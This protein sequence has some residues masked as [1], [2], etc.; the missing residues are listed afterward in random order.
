MQPGQSFSKTS[1]TPC[2]FTMQVGETQ[3][4]LQVCDGGMSV[5]L[6]VHLH[7]A[8]NGNSNMIYFYLLC[9]FCLSCLQATINC[10]MPTCRTAAPH[11]PHQEM[12][13]LASVSPPP[14][15]IFTRLWNWRQVESRPAAGV[16]WPKDKLGVSFTQSHLDV[17]AV[18]HVSVYSE[19]PGCFD[20]GLFFLS[21]TVSWKLGSTFC[22]H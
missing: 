3:H 13:Q 22:S 5:P 12:G 20:W 6:H 7:Q 8:Q 10:L 9:C 21:Q 19:R 16:R 1:W 17:T 2:N 15:E 4:R 14:P 18:A 11:H